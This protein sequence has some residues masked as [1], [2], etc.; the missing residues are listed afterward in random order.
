MKR[1]LTRSLMAALALLLAGA[2]HAHAGACAATVSSVNV[3]SDDTLTV[4]VNPFLCDCFVRP[5]SDTRV[6]FIQPPGSPGH[7]KIYAS[8]LTAVAS[9]KGVLITST[10]TPTSC[11]I[12]ELMISR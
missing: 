2:S 7:T 4:V 1:T 10:N 8:A 6:A 9:G 11:Q 12:N 3:A 5:Y